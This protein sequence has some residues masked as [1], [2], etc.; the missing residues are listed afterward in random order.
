MDTKDVAQRIGTTPRTLRQFLRS[1]YST[2]VP[3]GSGARYDFTER[4]LPTISKRFREWTSEGK[5]RPEGTKKKVEPTP[6]ATRKRDKQA[7]QD[8]LVWAEEDEIILDDIRDP[9]VRA[10]VKADAQ[11]AE[12]RLMEMLLA[13]NLHVFQLGNLKRKSA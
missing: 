4:E 7:E 3:V 9:R 11:A 2:F 1:A 12:D 5:P 8:R 6:T 10:R 13:R